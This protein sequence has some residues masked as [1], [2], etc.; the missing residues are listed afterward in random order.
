MN[1]IETLLA[2]FLRSSGVNT[3]TRSIEGGQLFI[4]LK[5]PNF[6][7]NR[8]AKQALDAGAVHVVLDE[9]PNEPLPEGKYTLVKNGLKALQ[10]LANA[11]RKTL[12]AKVVAIGG[13]NG[14][15]TTKELVTRVLLTKFRTFATPG[16]LN[17]HIGVPLTLLRTPLDTEII[18][19]EMGANGPTEIAELCLIAEPDF[20]LVTN[21]GKDHLEGFG[22]VE[23]VAS[24]NAEL[25]SYLKS[26]GGQIFINTLELHLTNMASEFEAKITYPQSHDFCHVEY[27]D[28]GQFYLSYKY[29]SDQE[30]TTKLIGKYNFANVATALCIGKYFETKELDTH[31]AIA[32]YQPSN[33][34][35]QIVETENNVVVSDAYNANPSSM[36]AAINNFASLKA[37]KKA[38]FLGDMLELGTQSEIE[39]EKIGELTL[40]SPF[41]LVG[42]VGQE[43]RFAFAKNPNAKY[44]ETPQQALDWLKL[45]KL[46]GFT[47]L[48]KGSR[49]LKMEQLIKEL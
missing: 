9:A 12:N 33:N 1:S 6:N 22:S 37:N 45:N 10:L 42:L 48:L 39:H 24:A 27:V 2:I 7:G 21:I 43:M 26:K 34:R 19:V 49:G 4:A 38:V 17:N 5:G 3:D 40:N 44:F 14:K 47:L 35:S 23:G 13:S 16:N 15:T 36:E 41:D 32:S 11:Y 28:N 30:H 46:K 8:F 18:V 31:L 25:Y 20:G 29:E